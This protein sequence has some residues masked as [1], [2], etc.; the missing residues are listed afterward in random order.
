[1]KTPTKK[2]KACKGTG[3]AP[4]ARPYRETLRAFQGG[5]THTSYDLASKALTAG[6]IAMRLER[7]CSWGFL[8]RKR[9]G[10]FWRYS[11]AK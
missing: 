3:M 10:K 8:A 5:R 11:L 6:A 4:L 9:E 2:C 1:M 7:L